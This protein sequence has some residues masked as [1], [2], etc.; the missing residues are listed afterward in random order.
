MRP[1]CA[2]AST[3]PRSSLNSIGVVHPDAASP[4]KDRPLVAQLSGR[5][6]KGLSLADVAS[7]FGVYART[8]ACES[9]GLGLLPERG[10]VGIAE[11]PLNV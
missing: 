11:F 5:Y 8:L 9:V 7:E 2:P 3:G 6:A 4:G 1:Q 10:E